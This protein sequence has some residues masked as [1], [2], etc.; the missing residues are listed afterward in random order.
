ME[1]E[2]ATHSSTFAWKISWKEGCGRLQSMGSQESDM[3]E[4]LHFFFFFTFQFLVEER[5]KSK[6]DV[7]QKEEL[8]MKVKNIEAFLHDTWL[9]K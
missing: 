7:N 1:K 6:E 2:A 4:R 9:R 8:K 3:T 5:S